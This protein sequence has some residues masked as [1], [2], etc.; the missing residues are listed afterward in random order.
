MCVQINEIVWSRNGLANPGQVASALYLLEN[1]A[2]C[3][4]GRYAHHF[5]TVFSASLLVWN[6]MHGLSFHFA[7]LELAYTVSYSGHSCPH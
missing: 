2:A 4:L 3:Y 5:F 6:V 7:K 1:V